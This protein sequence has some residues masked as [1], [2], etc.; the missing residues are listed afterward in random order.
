MGAEERKNMSDSGIACYRRR[1]ALA[2]A[3]TELYRALEL[4]ADGGST[5]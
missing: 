2:N 5:S 4:E 3:A 1:Y